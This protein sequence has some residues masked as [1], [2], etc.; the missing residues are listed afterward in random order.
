MDIVGTGVVGQ[1]CSH[2]TGTFWLLIIVS[3]VSLR[4]HTHAELY[5][6]LIKCPHVR[7]SRILT[8]M[9]TGLHI[10]LLHQETTGIGVNKQ[11]NNETFM[12][13]STRSDDDDDGDTDADDDDCG[14]P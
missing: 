9:G 7:D 5:I 10:Y 4:S 2:G 12:E 14:M 3:S 8:Y 11:I 1:E 6:C 13:V